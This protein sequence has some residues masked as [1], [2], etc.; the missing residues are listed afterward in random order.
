MTILEIE[1]QYKQAYSDDNFFKLSLELS[2]TNTNSMHIDDTIDELKRLKDNWNGYGAK[3]ISIIT[4]D[5][6]KKILKNVILIPE[7]FPTGRG[8]IQ[9]EYHCDK[10]Y[11]EIEVFDKKAIILFVEDK[12]YKNSISIEFDINNIIVNDLIKKYLF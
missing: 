8:S 10:K 11:L 5:N 9:I 3:K 2:G 1:E 7:I 6:A 4:I 12:N